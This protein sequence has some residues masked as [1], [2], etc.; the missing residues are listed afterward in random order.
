MSQLRQSKILSKITFAV[1]G[2]AVF[3]FSYQLG[4][5]YA[6][7]EKPDTTA[8]LLDDPIPLK[9]ISLID[10]EGAPFHTRNL[11]KH[12]TLVIIGDHRLDSC[13]QL[14]TRYVLTWNRLAHDES[15][16]SM[17][18]VAFLSLSPGEISPDELKSTIE[19]AHPDFIALTGKQDDLRQFAVQLGLSQAAEKPVECSDLDSIVSLID[20]DARIRAIF[21]GLTDPAVIAR[22]LET[23]ASR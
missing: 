16:Q 13:R 22:D 23:I 21:T 6:Q 14:L 8:L 11:E 17:T 2:L 10:E 3:L 20:P 7:P 15:L 1:L 9:T 4:N 19:F 12:W 5:R 18:R